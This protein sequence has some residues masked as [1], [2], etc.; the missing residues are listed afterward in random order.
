MLKVDSL[1]IVYVGLTSRSLKA[2][3]SE[4]RTYT[5]D[6]CYTELNNN[7]DSYKFEVVEYG[8]YNNQNNADVREQELIQQLRPL[9]NI[10]GAK[11]DD[12]SKTLNKVKT[13]FQ[14]CFFCGSDPVNLIPDP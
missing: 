5:G 10:R 13:K 8:Y 9:Y 1:E 3:K 12:N 11:A 6:E 4:H 2:R 14:S 7:P